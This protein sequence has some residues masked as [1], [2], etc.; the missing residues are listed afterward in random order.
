LEQCRWRAK[1]LATTQI[2]EL[3]CALTRVTLGKKTENVAELDILPNSEPARTSVTRK[4]LNETWARPKE[5]ASK[6]LGNVHRQIQPII[7]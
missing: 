6:V 3:I 2:N 1:L 7:E 5:A 4:T